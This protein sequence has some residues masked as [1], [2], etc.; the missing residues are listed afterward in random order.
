MS[1]HET[2]HDDAADIDS[3]V[4]PPADEPPGDEAPGGGEAHCFVHRDAVSTGTCTH[5]GNFGCDDCLGWLDK[6]LVCATCVLEKRVTTYAEIPWERRAELGTFVAM[7]KTVVEVTMRP[8]F[9]FTGLRP[10]ASVGDALV[11]RLVAMLPIFAVWSLFG[12]LGGL[13][14]GVSEGSAAEGAIIVGI[15]MGVAV[16]LPGG[17][18]FG[19]L[20]GGVIQHVLLL[21]FGGGKKGLN[22]T[23]LV[24]LYGGAVS[25]WLIIPCAHYVLGIWQIVLFITGYSKVHDEPAWKAAA[26]VLSPMVL[27]C[28]LYGALAFVGVLAEL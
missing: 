28:G 23:M 19:A 9:F 14:L 4:G 3:P 7:W 12:L 2:E 5:C 21:L 20:L 25:F 8:N 15:A 24:S 6:K 11:F 17:Y 22:A 16:L 27:C 13:A 18:L 10:D 1:E 26:A